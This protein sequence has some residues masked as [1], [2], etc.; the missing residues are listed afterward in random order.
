MERSQ[1]ASP[2]SVF[3]LPGVSHWIFYVY[4]GISLPVQWGNSPSTGTIARGQLSEEFNRLNE[5][6]LRQGRAISADGLANLALRR[7]IVRYNFCPQRY[8][9]STITG[10]D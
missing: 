6:G 5:Q 4:E 8:I 10:G 9:A 7:Y 3:F 1:D 2:G